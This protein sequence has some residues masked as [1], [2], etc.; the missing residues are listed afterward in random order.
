M[1]FSFDFQLLNLLPLFAEITVDQQLFGNQLANELVF[2]VLNRPLDLLVT[3]FTHDFGHHRLPTIFGDHVHVV[4][5]RLQPVGEQVLV[6]VV[7]VN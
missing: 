5:H 2:A 4:F 3:L 6:D 1:R 7:L